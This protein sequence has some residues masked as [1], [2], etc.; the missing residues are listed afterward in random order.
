M[1]SA[2]DRFWQK[3]D[4]GGDNGCWNWTAALTSSGYG[5]FMIQRVSSVAHRLSYTWLVGEIPEG[6]DL[7]HLCRNRRCVNPI[8]LEPV[9]R[10]ENLL[11]GKTIP[12]EH[13]E[14]THCPEGHEYNSENTYLKNGA[15]HCRKCRN[16]YTNRYYHEVIRKKKEENGHQYR[17]HAEKISLLQKLTS[18]LMKEN[19]KRRRSMMTKYNVGDKVR[20]LN[21]S[22]ICSG[23]DLTDGKLYDVVE[24]RHTGSIVI[25]D[26]ADDR[27]YITN[28]ELRYIELVASTPKYTTVKR[29]ANVG[30]RILITDAGITMGE[31]KNGDVFEVSGYYQDSSR[32]AVKTTVANMISINHDEYEVIIEDHSPNKPSKNARITQLESKVATLEAEVKA[33]QGGYAYG[34]DIAKHNSDYTGFIPKPTPNEQRKAVIER[35]KA[36]VANSKRKVSGIVASGLPAEGKRLE[37]S[38]VYAPIYNG[39]RAACDAEFI[40]NADKRTVVVLLKGIVTGKVYAK[41]IA[42]CAPDDVF[43][44]DIG[45]AIALGRALGLDVKEF[46]NAVKPTEVVVGTRIKYYCAKTG[47]F[48]F[49]IKTASES[50]ARTNNADL[51]GDDPNYFVKLVDDTEAKY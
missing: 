15:R 43:N 17:K 32:H 19:Q 25:I 16:L 40:I 7:D 4:K 27:L 46:E 9:T 21:A 29:K 14:K 23:D 26:D 44:A 3:V 2:E 34:V 30:E 31:Y 41:A 39:R 45:K 22:D 18:N 48:S 37:I 42:K 36:F 10:R 5:K 49:N 13:A 35:A 24:T 8:H 51:N 38:D 33:L 6:L 12:A 20:V 11:R 50:E 28:N 1:N 47:E